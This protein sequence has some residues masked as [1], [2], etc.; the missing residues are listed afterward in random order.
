MLNYGSEEQKATWAE[1]LAAGD[2]MFAFGITE[3]KHGSDATHMET[4][5]HKT[6]NGWIIQGEKTWNSGIHSAPAD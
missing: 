2:A 3:P 6:S 1:K 4:V 5:A